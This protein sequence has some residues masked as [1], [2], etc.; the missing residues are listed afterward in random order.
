[1]ATG[2]SLEP[3]YRC[4]AKGMPF[5]TTPVLDVS[6]THQMALLEIGKKILDIVGF[7]V[8]C[9]IFEVLLAFYIKNLDDTYI[10]VILGFQSPRM[11]I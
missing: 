5:L 6:I 4:S 9:H 11:I 3:Y 10:L 2:F 1:M 8:T 7:M